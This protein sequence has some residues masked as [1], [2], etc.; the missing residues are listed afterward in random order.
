MQYCTLVWHNLRHGV[1]FCKCFGNN[2]LLYF[3]RSFVHKSRSTGSLGIMG[4]VIGHSYM[5]RKPW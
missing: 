1:S 3:K 5:R 4:A 2:A